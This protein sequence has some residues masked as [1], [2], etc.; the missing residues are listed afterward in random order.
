[1]DPRIAISPPRPSAPDASIQETA[2]L[3]PHTSSGIPCACSWAGRHPAGP[4]A[5][6]S[7]CACC[8]SF[9][10]VGGR[11]GRCSTGTAP[12]AAVLEPLAA[13]QPLQLQAV[14]APRE[15]QLWNHWVQRYHPLGYRQ[16]IGTHL[17]YYVLD[18]RGRTLGCLLFDFATK[19]LPCRDRWIGW[20][21]QAFRKRLHLVVRSRYLLF[22]WVQVA[23][24]RRRASCRGTSVH[25]YLLAETSARCYRAANWQ[26]GRTDERWREIVPRRPPPSGGRR[27]RHRRTTALCACQDILDLAG[28]GRAR[29]Q[30]AAPTA[31]AQ[32][33][34]GGAVRLP[35][36]LFPATAGLRPDPR[37][38]VG[39][40]PTATCRSPGRWRPRRCAPPAP[41]SHS[42]HAETLYSPS[43]HSAPRTRGQGYRTPSPASQCSAACTASA[44]ACRSTST[45]TPTATSAWPHGSISPRWPPATS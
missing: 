11:R 31:V 26:L 10:A 9:T 15:A 23:R 8:G 22:P 43:C 25:G 30:L 19:S 37:R 28:G 14:T 4:T 40:L 45:S 32:H 29:P 5:C 39:V 12:Q 42:H 38:P 33:P 17:R 36:G 41:K 1:M 44:A 16:P 34:A 18:G 7:P 35:P 20:E 24:A 6:A 21:G 3:P 27:G 13:L 2:V